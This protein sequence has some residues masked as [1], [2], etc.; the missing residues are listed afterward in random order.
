ML[1][2]CIADNSD[3]YKFYLSLKTAFGYSLTYYDNQ[4]YTSNYCFC[5]NSFFTKICKIL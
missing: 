5:A 2:Q 4:N 1:F 3:E